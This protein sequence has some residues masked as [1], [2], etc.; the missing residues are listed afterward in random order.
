MPAFAVRRGL[1]GDPSASRKYGF[2]GTDNN[3]KQAPI[4]VNLRGAGAIV[5]GSDAL[6]N[7]I[8]QAGGLLWRG[9]GFH[10]QFGPV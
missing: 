8:Q 6:V 9:A 5:H 4:T 3:G 1:Q 2:G 10:G 7:L